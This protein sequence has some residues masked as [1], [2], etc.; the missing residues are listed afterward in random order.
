MLHFVG[1]HVGT[2]TLSVWRFSDMVDRWT[3]RALPL[4]DVYS[5]FACD[6]GDRTREDWL[7]CTTAI[8]GPA[9]PGPLLEGL[10]S[11]SYAPRL[12]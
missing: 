1:V 3:N 10:A 11:M 12:A 5:A 9:R 4:R 8:P 2:S 7:A 6:E